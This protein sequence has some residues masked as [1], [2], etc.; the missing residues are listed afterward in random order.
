MNK[1]DCVSP[2]AMWPLSK[3]MRLNQRLNARMLYLLL[4]TI[5]LITVFLLAKKFSNTHGNTWKGSV[6]NLIP[7]NQS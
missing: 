2:E 3:Y 6:L 5:A 7:I 4:Y 1:F